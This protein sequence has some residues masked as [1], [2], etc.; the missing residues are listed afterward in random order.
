MSLL[1]R[2]AVG[3]NV[4]TTWTFEKE[5]PSKDSPEFKRHIK[6]KSRAPNFKR[7]VEGKSRAHQFKRH[8]K[9]KS[10]AQNVAKTFY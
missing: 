8:I 10:S 2:F 9:G 5:A 6:G 1:D 3:Q 7:H 4:A